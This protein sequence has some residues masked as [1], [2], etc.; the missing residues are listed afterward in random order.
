MER[1]RVTKEAIDVAVT[2]D[3]DI[4]RGQDPLEKFY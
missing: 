1:T 4:G 2:L 3:K